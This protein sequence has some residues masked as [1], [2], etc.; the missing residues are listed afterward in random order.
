MTAAEVCAHLASR[1][2]A[3]DFDT[4]FALLAPGLMV[5]GDDL[6]RAFAELPPPDRFVVVGDAPDELTIQFLPADRHDVC[7][8]LRVGVAEHLGRLL[9]DRL[10]L[11]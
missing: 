3:R 4:A 6:A 5:D 1:I 9:I 2:V 10:E 11:A 8:E 7:F